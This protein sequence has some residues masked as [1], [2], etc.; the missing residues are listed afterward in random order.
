MDHHVIIPCLYYSKKF[1]SDAINI[2]IVI[3]PKTDGQS[4]VDTELENHLFGPKGARI[5]F[6]V[7]RYAIETRVETARKVR[8]SLSEMGSSVCREHNFL[9]YGNSIGF[10][11]LAGIHLFD[12]GKAWPRCCIASGQLFYKRGQIVSVGAASQKLHYCVKHLPPSGQLFLPQ[13][14][15]R[16]LKRSKI[17]QSAPVVSLPLRIDAGIALMLEKAGSE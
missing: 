11:L 10:P 14:N 1:G 13:S 9:L 3:S 7:I 17:W 12:S 4:Y 5:F 6:D 15:V 2:P 16:G 8:F